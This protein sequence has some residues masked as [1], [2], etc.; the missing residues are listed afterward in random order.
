MRTLIK[1]PDCRAS[2]G[3]KRPFTRKKKKRILPQGFP[4]TREKKPNFFGQKRVFSG[5]GGKIAFGER[6]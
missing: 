4:K 6:F 2:D 1:D 5:G 3:K